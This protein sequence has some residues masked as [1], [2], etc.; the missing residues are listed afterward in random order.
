MKVYKNLHEAVLETAREWVG[1]Q[2]ISGNM[3]FDNARFQHLMKIA[4]W[5][6]R[7][8]WCLYFCELCCTVP[9]YSGKSKTHAK[10]LELFS[11]SAVQTYNNFRKDTSGLFVVDHIPVP[12]AIA[13]WQTYR[14][15]K[16]DWTGHGAIVELVKELQF[17][18]IDGNTNSEGGREGK[19]IARMAGSYRHR[20]DTAFQVNNGL[21]LKG[22]IKLK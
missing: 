21:R 22:F 17:S 10:L 8:A 11:G 7:E 20:L 16:A 4:E 3:G 12:G 14:D 19:E 1:I 13:I 2:E 9:M 5:N 6:E 18:S 15:G